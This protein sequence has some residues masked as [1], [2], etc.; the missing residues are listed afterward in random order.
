MKLLVLS[1]THG[2]YEAIAEAIQRTQP[3]ALIHLGDCSGDVTY[4]MLDLPP[5]PIYQVCG[6][7]DGYTQLAAELELELDGKCFFILHGHTR[8]AK[9]GDAAM[10]AA[11]RARG[12]EIVL[13]GHTHQARNDEKDGIRLVNPGTARRRSVFGKYAAT[14]AVIETDADVPKICIEQY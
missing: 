9:N 11:A 2:D 6:N 10:L 3:D 4:A 13:Y 14:Y 1:D 7:C 8:D 12:A 5:L